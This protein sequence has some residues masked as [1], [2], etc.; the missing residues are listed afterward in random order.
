MSSKQV[1]VDRS[2]LIILNS[3]LQKSI[4]CSPEKKQFKL[5]LE[6]LLNLRFIFSSILFSN[7]L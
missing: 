4:Q 5:K 3:N 7:N 1:G 6:N 2:K